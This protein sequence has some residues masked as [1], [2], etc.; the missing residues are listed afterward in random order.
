MA[1]K[2]RPKRVIT[3]SSPNVV[4]YDYA[5]IAEGSGFIDYYLFSSE[6]NSAADYHLTNKTSVYSKIPYT[7]SAVTTTNSK[8]IDLDFEIEFNMPRDIEG[9]AITQFY[10]GGG[11]TVDSISAYVVTTIYHY[12]GTTATS[13]GTAQSDTE[14]WSTSAR[15]LFCVPIDISSRQHFKPNDILRVNVAVW[16]VESNGA[17][18]TN[19]NL[20]HDPADRNAAVDDLPTNSHIFIPFKIT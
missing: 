15:K 17:S 18:D 16:A 5:D 11:A 2:I 4:S 1:D 10:V 7:Q 3:Q 19:V 9:T 14:T 20:Q 8:V 12:D 13:I 6:T